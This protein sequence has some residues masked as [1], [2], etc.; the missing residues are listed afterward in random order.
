MSFLSMMEL[1][2]DITKD[3]EKREKG[4][5]N[6]VVLSRER[7]GVEMLQKEGV[8]AQIARLMKGKDITQYLY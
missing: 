4:A 7:S 5:A 8:I 2:F 6:L 3:K 1:V